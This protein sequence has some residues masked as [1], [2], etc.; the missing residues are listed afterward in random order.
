MSTSLSVLRARLTRRRL[1]ALGVGVGALT[2][3]GSVGWL[4]SLPTPAPGRQ[5]LSA[6]E[7]ELLVRLAEVWF[8]PG[9]P[10]GVA[11]ADVDIGGELDRVLALL[12]IRE[13]RALH[14]LLRVV[15]QL[16]RASLSSTTRFSE[17]PLP[18]RRALIV[19]WEASAGPKRQLAGVL[20]LLAGLS[21]FEDERVRLAIGHTFGCPLPLPVIG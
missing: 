5:A 14:A 20:R 12:S 13:Q 2:I 18:E 17:L 15:D 16:P 1:L 21:F 4:V 9:N 3:V 19:G 10:L 11:A 8:P 6:R 7:S